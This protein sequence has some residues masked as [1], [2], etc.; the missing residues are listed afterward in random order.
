MNFRLFL[1]SFWHLARIQSMTRTHVR[2]EVCA[3]AAVAALVQSMSASSSFCH[4]KAITYRIGN[5]MKV[6]LTSESN[7]EILAS[8]NF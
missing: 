6:V 3:V 1:F 8:L 2:I 7:A 5:E 4:S